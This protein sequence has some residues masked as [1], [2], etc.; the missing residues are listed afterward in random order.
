MARLRPGRTC[1][2]PKSQSWSRYSV[3]KPRKNYIRALPHT[4][5]QA[6]NMGTLSDK[7]DM[8][9]TLNTQQPIQLRSN[10]LESARRITNHYLE[11]EILGQYSLKLLVFPHLVI[12][13]HKMAVGAGADRISRGMSLSYGTPVSV[14][15][16]LRAHQPL[17]MI[18][19]MKANRKVA[20]TA[21]KRAQ[22]KLSGVYKVIV[23]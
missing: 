7:Y 6:F 12:R 18:R 1:R 15:A 22:G 11:T 3:K 17:F 13:E 9:L 16:R 2:S 14:A 8:T 20:V 5:L 23:E 4:A 21:F 10:T 19:T